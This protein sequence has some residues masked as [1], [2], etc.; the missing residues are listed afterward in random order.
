MAALD[1]FLQEQG[2]KIQLTNDEILLE[3]VHKI[4]VTSLIVGGIGIAIMV[5]IGIVLPPAASLMYVIAFVILVVVFRF[6]YRGMRPIVV[7]DWTH[8][9]MVRRSVYFFVNSQTTK[10]NGYQGIDIR[11]KDWS[12]QSSE[13]VDEYQKTIFLKTADGE[14]EVVDFYTEEEKV[15]PELLELEQI[16][17]KHLRTSKA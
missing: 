4:N 3:K 6:N 11:T 14:V 5:L 13:G 7:F 1:D 2:Y 12:S 17:D 16:I 9:M 10:I 8:S 15:E